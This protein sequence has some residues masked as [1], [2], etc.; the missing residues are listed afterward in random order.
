[1]VKRKDANK[2]PVYYRSESSLTPKQKSIRE[3]SLQVLINVRNNKK[4]LSKV[5]NEHSISVNTVL[6]NTNAFK[7]ING[8]W[9]AKKYDKIPRVMKINENRREISF[10]ISD[11]R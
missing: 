6:H 10:E 9:R 11:S 4:S 2:I 8:R 3:K 7:K 1:M 5:S